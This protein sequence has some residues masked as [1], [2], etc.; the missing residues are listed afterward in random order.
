MNEHALP[1][2]QPPLLQL[3]GPVTSAKAGVSDQSLSKPVIEVHLACQKCT[4]ES[5]IAFPFSPNQSS[6]H[7]QARLFFPHLTLS[8]IGPTHLTRP[9]QSRGP[10]NIHGATHVHTRLELLLPAASASPCS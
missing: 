9:F 6:C 10:H 5:P 3:Q 4:S 7:H 1:C 8:P 2:K